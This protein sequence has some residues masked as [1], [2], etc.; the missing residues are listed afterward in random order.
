[1]YFRVLDAATYRRI[2]HSRDNM[3]SEC[4][5]INGRSNNK[6]LRKRSEFLNDYEI[7]CFLNSNAINVNQN[8]ISS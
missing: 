5:K 8:L 3:H 1:M 4:F 6:K 7:L 2:T